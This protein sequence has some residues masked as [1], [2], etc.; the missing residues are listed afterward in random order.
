MTPWANEPTPIVDSKEVR[1]YD[2][3]SSGIARDLERRLRHAEGLVKEHM[4]IHQADVSA[5]T[6]MNRFLSWLNRRDA[7]LAAAEREDA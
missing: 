2:M 3:V 5:E 1:E 6:K 4:E 7:Y